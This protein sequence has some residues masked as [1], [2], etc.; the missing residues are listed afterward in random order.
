VTSKAILVAS[1]I[2]KPEGEELS[3]LSGVADI[4][5][6][7][8][9]LVGDIEPA[10]LRDRFSGQLLFTLRSRA[11]GGSSDA[12]T[13]RRYKRLAAAAPDYDLIDLEG[14]RDL[15][16]ELLAAVP[17]DRRIISWHGSPSTF[18]DL[19][20]VF[21]RLATEAARFYKLVPG[22]TDPAHALSPLALLNSLQ[23]DDLSAFASGAAGAWTRLIAPRLGAPLVYGS[24]TEKPAAEGQPSIAGLQRDFGLP[25]LPGIER[26]NGLVG[27][28]VAHS[29]SPA[30][31]NGLYRRLGLPALYLPFHVEAFGDFWLDIVESGSLQVL[32]FDLRGLSVTAP[33]KGAALA[34]AGAASPLA[35]TVGAANTLTWN[36]GVW[37]AENT[38]PEGTMGALASR[39]MTVEGLS[40]AVLGAGGAGRAAVFSLSHAGARVVLFNRGV[41]RGRRMAARL[42]VPFTPLAELDP[43]RFDLL[44]HATA[45]GRNEEDELPFDP[46]FLHRDT[47]VV[48]L[49]YKESEP[50]RLVREVRAQGVRAIDGRELLLHQAVSQFRLMTGEEL[51]LEEGREILGLEGGV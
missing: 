44:I 14:L 33:H 38:D 11:E 32:G 28:P 8:A 7:R 26:L 9:D 2:E 27:C 15:H 10:W 48:D 1:L 16:P 25:E 6:V 12:S 35:E 50:T 41:E 29:L 13:A 42:K 36:Q 30:L 45:L 34:V 46:R 5:E 24:V 21:E 43:S 3:A 31:H 17:E 19:T 51:P 49:V 40:A 20:A 22:A 18:S 39:R 37:E 47:V 4:L 23:R